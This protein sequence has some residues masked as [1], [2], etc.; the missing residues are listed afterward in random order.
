M[1]GCAALTHGL[2]CAVVKQRVA[3]AMDTKT[4]FCADVK[5][6]IRE[7]RSRPR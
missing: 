6:K 2:K 3:V 5:I 1:A 4:G 7:Q